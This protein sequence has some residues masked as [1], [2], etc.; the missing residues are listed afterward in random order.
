MFNPL[1]AN[2]SQG[3]IKNN[4][5]LNLTYIPEQIVHREKQVNELTPLFRL[6]LLNLPPENVLIHG[7][8]GTGKTMVVGKM[9]DFLNKATQERK[10]T[11]I[12][13]CYINCYHAKKPLRILRAISEQL[14]NQLSKDKDYKPINTKINDE[15]SLLYDMFRV[16]NLNTYYV[17]IVLDEIDKLDKD[18][19]KDFIIRNLVRAN[20]GSNA[21]IAPWAL[22]DSNIGLIC[23]ANNTRFT[24]KLSVGT[25]DS[26]GKMHLF[27][28]PPYT[29]QEL[30]DIIKLRIKDALNKDC[31]SEEI[32]KYIAK[33]SKELDAEART[34]INLLRES[35]I[36]A[37][38]ERSNKI[39]IEHVTKAKNKLEQEDIWRDIKELGLHEKWSY[40]ALCITYNL[41]ISGIKYGEL[42][43]VGKARGDNLVVTNNEMMYEVYNDLMNKYGN[44]SSI[45]ERQFRRYFQETFTNQGLVKSKNQGKYVLYAPTLNPSSV[46][47][48]LLKE[49]SRTKQEIDKLL[50]KKVIEILEKETVNEA[51]T[52]F[53]E[54]GIKA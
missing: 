24:D 39:K 30:L 36:I 41:M 2:I 11:N 32:L 18:E 26:F 45:K 44:Q 34:A 22:K 8:A 42:R 31:I 49:L 48:L 25:M 14:N 27:H 35:A 28:Y 38:N 40:L 19:D 43:K 29:E 12:L 13:T 52:V 1:T 20:E 17:I 37:V 47:E 46:K 23:I 51:L 10:I 9:L 53:N 5:L 3:I 4:K 21:G 7:R 54:E 33:Y 16:L 6:P 50:P 15:I